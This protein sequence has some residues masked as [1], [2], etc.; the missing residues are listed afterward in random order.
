MKESQINQGQA[1]IGNYQSSEVAQPGEGAFDLPTTLIAG[2]NLLRLLTAVFPIPSI[3]NQQA[4]ASL[5]Q[6]VPQLVRIIRLISNEAFGSGFGTAPALPWH[7]DGLK[8]GFGQNYF[9]GRG[10]GHG[11]SQRNTLAVDHHQPLRAF[12]PLGGADAV[13]PFFAGAKLASIKASSQSRRPSASRKVRQIFNQRSCSSQAFSRRQ[14]VDGLGYLL[15][16]SRQGAPVR[17]TQRMPSKTSRL[18]ALGR[19]P[20]EPGFSEGNRGAI[21]N[22]WLSLRNLEVAAIGP[23]PIAYY[24]KPSKMSSF[25]SW[26]ANFY[27]YCNFQ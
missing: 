24:A 10:R 15:G 18:S 22:H 12:P 5:A 4:N 27:F 9:R 8:G 13:A 21:F 23:P 20:L 3:R 6:L 19:P 11:A 16:K 2:R 26:L 1:F 7:L 25:F 17:R 14:Q